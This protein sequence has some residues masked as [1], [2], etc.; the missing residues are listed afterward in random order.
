MPSGRGRGG[1]A[2][3]MP[4]ASM[5]CPICAEPALADDD[6]CESCGTPL[7][8]REAVAREHVEVSAGAVAG[9]SD[10]GLR[11]ERNEDAVFVAAEAGRAV[12]VVCDGVSVSAAP[13]VASQVAADTAGERLLHLLSRPAGPAVGVDAMTDA[14]G[15]GGDAVADVPWLAR[16][17]R[18]GPSCTVVAAVWDGVT[19]TIG[20]AGDSRAYWV[21]EAGAR[22]LTVDHSWAQDQVASGALSVGAAE[23]D[24]R[25][26]VITRW[27]GDDAPM[28]ADTATWSPA[29]AGRLVLCTDGL[30]NHLDGAS[31]LSELIATSDGT[32]LTVARRLVS[33]ALARGG[34]D[35]VTV[36]VADVD[37]G[38]S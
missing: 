1:E 36:A 32:P 35:N 10:R 4:T 6:Y 20:W 26:H 28:A 17:D 29:G 3:V 23:R 38:G 2:V 21:D 18:N 13:H 16:S 11:H 30:W 5:R 27:L 9:V 24:P 7:G 34:H 37:P 14:L 8:R 25:A 33:T 31:D 22:L 19:V 12:A 15:L